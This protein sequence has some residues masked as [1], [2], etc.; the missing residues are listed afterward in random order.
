MW[1]I[2]ERLLRKEKEEAF[3]REENF[4]QAESCGS[5]A[6]CLSPQKKKKKATGRLFP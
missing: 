3:E 1:R 2:I 4:I 6:M 5:E